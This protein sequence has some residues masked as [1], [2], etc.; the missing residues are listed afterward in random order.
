MKFFSG[1]CSS[2]IQRTRAKFKRLVRLNVPRLTARFFVL[3]VGTV[4][5]GALLSSVLILSLKRQQ[6]IDDTRITAQRVSSVI[7]ASL[8]HA[9]LSNDMPMLERLFGTI[10]NE[11]GGK[12]RILNTDGRVWLSSIPIEAGQRFEPNDPRCRA[13]HLD[14]QVT[15]IGMAFPSSQ[16]SGEVLLNVSMIPNQPACHSCHASSARSLGLLLF[17]TPLADWQSELFSSLSQIAP[18]AAI[19][20]VLLMGLLIPTLN[21]FVIQPVVN[22]AAG[23][24]EFG[25]G[26]LDYQPVVR[27]SDDELGELATA[28]DTMR[29][30]LKTSL[31]EKER[32]NQE[33]QM[34]NE[35]ACAASQL[36]DPQQILDLTIKI[37]VSSLGVQA[38]AI[39]LLDR[40][41]GRFSIHACKG[42]A[43]C[44]ELDCYLWRFNQA[45]VGLKQYDSKVVSLPMPAETEQRMERDAQGRFFVGVPLRAKGVVVG[46]M[47]FVTQPGQEVT[48]AGAKTLRLLGQEIGLAL[49]NAIRFQNARA[50]ATLEER[51]RLAREMHDSL[52]Q[53][54]GYLKLKASLTDALLSSGEIAQAQE[55]LR[56]VKEIAGETYIDVREAIF[57]LRRGSSPGSEFLPSL[58]AYIADYRVHYGLDV[59]LVM[60]NDHQP[61][62][63]DNVS[64]QL[65]RIIQEALTNARKH[66][67]ANHITVRIEQ[68][69][70]RWRVVVEDDG[71]GF[72]PQRV[73]KAGDQFLGLHIVRERAHSIG[74]EL[75]IES[76]PGGGTRMIV[77]LPI[78]SEHEDDRTVAYP[79]GG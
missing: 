36:L 34:L 3:V 2:G 66:A 45:L 39:H 56:E 23:A 58:Q 60:P 6:L 26:N 13:C 16:V 68:A 11:A 7:W 74:A 65:E 18:S 76:H 10:A 38:G 42:I 24:R 32:R 64:V 57:G 53:A 33:L 52:A 29:Q 40:E 50:Q 62:F 67:Q 1:L 12:V 27:R 9:M 28:F 21:K 30:Q 31:A 46:A 44:P 61:S 35:I 4:F 14:A 59:R 78:A 25:A 15:R 19:I 47:T 72:D 69:D 63:A 41:G 20:F 8:E 77:R 43:K 51:E 55:N 49:S 79:I 22:L 73:P 48:E 17:E 37:A 54:L 5:L 71:Q 75:G 70:L